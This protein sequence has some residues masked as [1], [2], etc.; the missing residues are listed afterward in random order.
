MVVVEG[1]GVGWKGWKRWGYHASVGTLHWTLFSVLQSIHSLSTTI[2]IRLAM[3]PCGIEWYYMILH[4]DITWHSR[5]II[6]R[7]K[8]TI[9][10]SRSVCSAEHIIVVDQDMAH[11]VDTTVPIAS[12]A[13]D[14]QLFW[15][16]IVNQCV[17]G[18]AI[19]HNKANWS[20]LDHHHHHPSIHPPGLAIGI[21]WQYWTS[22]Q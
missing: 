12:L 4:D 11:I 17:N 9:N 2:S 14:V 10:H 15:P 8:Q 18:P 1:G 7:P 21:R 5:S 13:T 3:N 6:D 20:T 19:N 16:Y 22:M